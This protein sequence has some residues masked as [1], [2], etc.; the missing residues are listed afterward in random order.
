VIWGGWD[1]AQWQ[2]RGW[3][4]AR[5]FQRVGLTLSTQTKREGSER[6]WMWLN[7]CGWFWVMGTHRSGYLEGGRLGSE[8]GGG[9]GVVW[10]HL[11]TWGPSYLPSSSLPLFSHSYPLLGPIGGLGDPRLC[12]IR[13]SQD[14]SDANVM[15][16]LVAFGAV[17]NSNR[18][19]SRF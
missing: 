14:G 2:T 16:H 1:L 13:C 18:F 10:S 8:Q 7:V 17:S 19:R 15:H 11:V 12:Y 9:K 6:V 5:G 4:L 3:G